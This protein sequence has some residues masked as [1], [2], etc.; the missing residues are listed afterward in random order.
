MQA[1]AT[2]G[3][4]PS[5]ELVLPFP[6]PLVEATEFRTTWLSSSLGAL[7]DLGL[8]ERYQAELPARFHEPVLYSVAGTWVPLEIA[9]EHYAACSRLGLQ[10]SEMQEITRAVTKRLHDTSLS[11]VVRLVKQSGATPWHAMLQLNRFWERVWRGG[12]VRVTKLGPKDAIIE[13]GGWPVAESEYVQQAMPP[14][15]EAVLS[16]FCRRVFS[17]EAPEYRRRHVVPVHVSW[18]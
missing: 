4:E 17:R 3:A 9:H 7:R 14:I 18:V 1:R 8:M 16:L 12:G 13:F 6:D 15:T 2:R 5:G 10:R 11:T